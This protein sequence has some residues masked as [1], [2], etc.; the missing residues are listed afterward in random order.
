MFS[1]S[2]QVCF[3]LVLAL[4]ADAYKLPLPPPL[5]LVESIKA[6]LMDNL[7]ELISNLVPAIS[8]ALIIRKLTS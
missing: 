1:L 4:A 5:E 2:S 3:G 7:D 6:L 8:V